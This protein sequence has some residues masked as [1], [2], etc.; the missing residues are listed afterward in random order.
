MT[1]LLHGSGTSSDS[2][3]RASP[4]DQSLGMYHPKDDACSTQKR[5][6]LPLSDGILHLTPTFPVGLVSDLLNTHFLIF[7]HLSGPSASPEILL[8]TFVAESATFSP[9]TPQQPKEL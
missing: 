3:E 9:Y 1:V 5:G 8:P 6:L 4:E 2:S 7:A